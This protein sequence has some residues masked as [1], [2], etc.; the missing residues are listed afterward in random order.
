MAAIIP[1][2]Y[3]TPGHSVLWE[4]LSAN[5]NKSDYVIDNISVTFVNDEDATAFCMRFGIP[6]A[7]HNPGLL[8]RLHE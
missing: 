7:T 5:V 1:I 4:W 6:A 3:Y 2:R 8:N